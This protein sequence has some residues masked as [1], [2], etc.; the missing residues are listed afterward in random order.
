MSGGAAIPEAWAGHTVINI[1]GIRRD[2]ETEWPEIKS[3]SNVISAFLEIPFLQ[4]RCFLTSEGLGGHQ[5][6]SP[7]SLGAQAALGPCPA[8]G[9]PLILQPQ[10]Q[11]GLRV[12]TW[13]CRS[14]S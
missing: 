4:G 11:E 12:L 9:F 7:L 2:L 3:D 5:E 13:C 6:L 10:R 14:F 8:L 1:R